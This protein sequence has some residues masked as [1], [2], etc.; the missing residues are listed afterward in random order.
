M[1][2]SLQPQAWAFVGHLV[3]KFP[4]LE[5]AFAEHIDDQRG[6]L[7]PHVFMAEV[8]RWAE[9]LIESSPSLLGALLDE[10]ER[11]VLR[12][13]DAVVNLID[14]SFVENLPYPDQPA[15]A[16]RSMLPENVAK[17]LRH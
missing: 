3:W 15:A 2:A 4:L 12:G 10:L 13:D 17:L 9:S 8:E 11:A 6:T 1:T 14:V 5:A 16:I 7:L